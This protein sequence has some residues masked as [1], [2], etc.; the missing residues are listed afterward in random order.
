MKSFTRPFPGLSPAVNDY[1][2]SAILAVVFT[3][4]SY[5]VGLGFGWITTIDPLEVFAV[6]TSYACTYLCVRERRFNYVLAVITTASYCVLF[7]QMGLLASMFLQI[8]LIPTVIYGWFRWKS[9]ADPRPVRHVELKWV[10]GYLVLT[11]AGY[12]GAVWLVSAMGGNLPF[13]DAAILAGTILAQLLLDNKRIETWIVWLIV[14]VVAIY[15][16][17]SSGLFLV[18]VQYLAFLANTVWGYLAWNK[19][20]REYR[21]SRAVWAAVKRGSARYDAGLLNSMITG[22]MRD[23]TYEDRLVV[24]DEGVSLKHLTLTERGVGMGRIT[25]INGS[26]T[27]ETED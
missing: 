11:V 25:A 3:G 7:W 14:D 18:G 12:F 20:M 10:P 19:S 24:A 27:F 22:P 8:Y 4:G 13:F 6:F 23:Q 2:F 5:W 9:D 17:F 16:Y 1:I 26:P 15:V 21:V